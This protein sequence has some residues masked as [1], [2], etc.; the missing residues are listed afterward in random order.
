[1]TSKEVKRSLEPSDIN[2]NEIM[3]MASMPPKEFRAFHPGECWKVQYQ[4]RIG[5]ILVLPI[6][7][8]SINSIS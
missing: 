2:T 6:P 8:I 5:K 3:K 7:F 4:S 1:M